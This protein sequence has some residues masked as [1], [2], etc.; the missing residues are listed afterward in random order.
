MNPFQDYKIPFIGLKEGVHDY[1]FRLT[2]SFFSLFDFGE[3]DQCD[4]LANIS[5]EKFS[6]MM[7][8]TFDISGHVD[9]PCDRC[10]EEIPVEIEGEY[11][12]II[13]YGDKT[14]L[15]D[16]ILVFGSNEF[17]IDIHHYLYEYVH[18]SLPLKRAHKNMNDCQLDYELEETLPDV[19]EDKSE[20]ETDPRWNALKGLNKT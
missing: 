13:K 11:L 18:L 6:N 3:I 20:E 16:E 5:L 17:E 10:G 4:I 12:L 2:E 1:Q 7:Q 9:F 19:D 15:E 14:N 8:L